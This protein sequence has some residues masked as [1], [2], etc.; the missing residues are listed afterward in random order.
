MIFLIIKW[1]R[2]RLHVDG[3]KFWPFN[4]IN[5]KT[6][7]IFNY[8]VLTY[9]TTWKPWPYTGMHST[10]DEFHPKKRN[11]TCKQHLTVLPWNIFLQ[12]LFPM[13]S[14]YG[15]LESYLIGSEIHPAGKQQSH[16]NT[17]NIQYLHINKKTL[18]KVKE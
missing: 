10:R 13:L 3:M 6:F 16:L 2:P 11:F 9:K 14:R 17:K 1:V 4:F 12:V 15:R 8:F 5:F 18:P 7:L